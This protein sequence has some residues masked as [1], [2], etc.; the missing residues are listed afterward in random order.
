MEHH[1]RMMEIRQR[2]PRGTGRRR[3]PPWLTGLHQPPAEYR[4]MPWPKTQRANP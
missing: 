3:R 4:R 1:L 2:A